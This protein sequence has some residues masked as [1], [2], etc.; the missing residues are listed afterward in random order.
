MKIIWVAF[1][2]R[3][4]INQPKIL[5]RLLNLCRLRNTCILKIISLDFLVIIYNNIS[6]KIL[7]LAL[8][9]L[10]ISK[11]ILWIR[12]YSAN[13]KNQWLKCFLKKFWISLRSLLLCVIRNNR[14]F[15]K[16]HLLNLNNRHLNKIQVRVNRKIFWINIVVIKLTTHQKMKKFY[17]KKGIFYALIN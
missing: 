12:M 10:K 2:I 3:I 11:N 9:N 1:L 4:N 17:L 14:L 15:L 13:L 6:N 5:L 8:F 16:L 7:T